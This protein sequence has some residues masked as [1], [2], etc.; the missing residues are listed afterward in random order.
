MF[1]TSNGANFELSALYGEDID[2]MHARDF[3]ATLF[4][5]N[6]FVPWRKID[7]ASL[8]EIKAHLR[9]TH[10]PTATNAKDKG[11]KVCTSI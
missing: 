3:A 7:L 9:T 6:A 5:S 10:N 4:K 1:T 2:N 11:K 8:T